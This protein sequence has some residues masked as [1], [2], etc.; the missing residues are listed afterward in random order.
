MIATELS[1]RL[2]VSPDISLCKTEIFDVEFA[3]QLA[4]LANV[5]KE[6]REKLKRMIKERVK[7][8]QLDITYKLGKNCKHE[9]LGRF[10][11]VRGLGLQGIHKDIRSAIA[12]EYYHDIDI[13]NAQPTILKQYCEKNGFEHTHLKRYINEREEIL[14]DVCE[15][16]NIERWEAKQRITSIIFGGN[17]D[18]MPTWFQTDFLPEI[19]RIQ[20]CVWNMN[21]DRLKWLRS[22]PNSHGKGMAYILQTEEREC[23][24][25]MDKALSKRGRSLEVLMHDGG[26]VRKKDKETVFPRMLLTEIEQ[27]IKSSTGYDVSLIVK[28]MKTSYTKQNEDDEY[29]VV[30]ENFELTHFKLMNPPC[31]VRII[32]K[33]VQLLTKADLNLMYDNL[34]YNN[35]PFIQRW[36]SDPDMRTY[37]KIEFCPMKELEPDVFNLFQGFSIEP[38]EGDISAVHQVLHI[39]SDNNPIVFDYIE[40]LMAWTMQKP[41]EKSGVCLIIQSPEEG[42]GKDTYF[43]LIGRICGE[44]FM[45]TV[46]AENTIFSRFNG[47]WKQKLLV[48]MEELNFME[49]KKYVDQFKSII[50]ADTITFEEK[51]RDPLTLSNFTTFVGTTNNEVPV[52]IGN[53]DR[54]FAL[55]R[56]SPERVGDI[57]FW[58]TIQPI[59]HSKETAQAYYHH[60][61]HVDLTDFNPRVIPKTE[62]YEE[63]K[64]TFIPFDARFFQN[65]IEINYTT[66]VHSWKAHEII[67]QLKQSDKF[68]RSVTAI[69]RRL[70]EYVKDGIIIKERKSHYISYSFETEKMKEYL[71]KRGW[72]YEL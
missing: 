1:A 39:I 26:L 17:A 16:M 6:E 34:Y 61:L 24:M 62:Y 43:D 41:Y 58:N 65:Y 64:E 53:K 27:E 42:A 46:S 14:T 67:D 45:N 49:T 57:E 71:Q 11:S 15:V 38:V 31:Y 72:W 22:Q 35:T 4:Q 60:L 19:H 7:G 28:P 5:Q 18:N 30:K 44:Y 32:D 68:E 50:T 40:K 55:F 12:Q 25:A 9:F 52:V 8:N 36:I 29:N 33:S 2:E 59:L 63:V 69:G 66:A 54:R 13:V 51:G 23:L 3:K 48:K 70:R 10:C 21:L 56:A 20:K 37:R 47:S